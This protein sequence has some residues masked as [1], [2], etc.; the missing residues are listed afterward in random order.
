MLQIKLFLLCI[1]TLGSFNFSSVWYCFQAF[2]KMVKMH[3]EQME[4]ERQNEM[5]EKRRRKEMLQRQKRFLEA[6]FEGDNDE[7]LA[8]LKEVS[9]MIELLYDLLLPHA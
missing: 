3:Q 7:L 1:T 8:I 4:R 6:A 9:M 5:E 2:A